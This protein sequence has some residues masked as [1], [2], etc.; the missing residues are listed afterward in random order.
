ME[1]CGGIVIIYIAC[2]HCLISVGNVLDRAAY[3]LRAQPHCGNEDMRALA[4]PLQLNAKSAQSMHGLS[5]Q[6]GTGSVRER[7]K[8]K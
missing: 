3:S 2:S 7:Q 8:L 1:F 4:T 6:D 5:L